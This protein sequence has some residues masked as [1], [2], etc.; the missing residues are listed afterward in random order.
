[1]AAHDPS[2]YPGLEKLAAQLRE[3]QAEVTELEERWM[4]LASD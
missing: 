3:I 4:E 1:M 2:D